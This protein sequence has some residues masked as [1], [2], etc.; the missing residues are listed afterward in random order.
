VQHSNGGVMGETQ[1]I[2]IGLKIERARFPP[3][4]VISEPIQL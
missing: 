1:S 3:S 2:V 4:V